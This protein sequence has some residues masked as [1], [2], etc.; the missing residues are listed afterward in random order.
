M[1]VQVV[2]VGQEA[3]EGHG[4]L[5]HLLLLDVLVLA[6]LGGHNLGGE[7]LAGRHVA[8]HRLG[9]EGN[10]LRGGVV[11]LLGAEGLD[12][13]DGGKGLLRDGNRCV[14]IVDSGGGGT[15]GLRGE[16]LLAAHAAL[17]GLLRL[18]SGGG[19]SHGDHG[20]L[21]RNHGREGLG[22]HKGLLVDDLGEDKRALDLDGGSL[23][24]RDLRGNG[25]GD[26]G[27]FLER[28]ARLAAHVCSGVGFFCGGFVAESLNKVQKL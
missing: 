13:S 22:L 20:R 2:G 3:L 28:S 11:L 24:G 17:L 14:L 27:L 23:H 25:G 21:G 6:V 12:G 18:G 4:H 10:A 1:S 15:S 8:V 26:G 7:L 5:L 16:G 19:S 9:G